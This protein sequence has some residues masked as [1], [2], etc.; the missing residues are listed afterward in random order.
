[1]PYGDYEI[2]RKVRKLRK[3]SLLRLM[4]IHVEIYFVARIVRPRIGR[5]PFPTPTPH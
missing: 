2:L 4:C 1:V 5:L 3:L